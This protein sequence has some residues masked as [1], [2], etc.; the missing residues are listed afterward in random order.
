MILEKYQKLSLRNKIIATLVLFILIIFALIYF[1][2]VP[3]IEDIKTMSKQ[4]E[5]QKI[6]LETKYV[7]GNNLRQLTEDLKKIEPKLN[8]LDQIFI[9]KNREL[10]FITTL[11]NEAN[12]SQV[13]QKINLNSP[14][15]TENQQFKKNSLQLITRGGFNK[16]L[17]YLMNLE[18]LDYYI[19]IKLLE[20]AP[21]S[22]D[23]TETNGTPTAGDETT[24]L[25]M[26]INADTYWE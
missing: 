7:K 15:A 26:L 17:K 22:F 25:N 14:Q 3:T 21:T 13:S 18:S 5:E 16:Q 2:V 20:I 9:N 6:D 4:I 23:N 11:E 12:K 8:L 19:N 1:I 10:E 24:G